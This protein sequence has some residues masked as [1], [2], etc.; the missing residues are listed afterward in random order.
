MSSPGL[1]DALLLVGDGC[2]VDPSVSLGQSSPGEEQLV[3]G[4]TVGL[5]PG[6]RTRTHPRPDGGELGPGSRNDPD[7]QPH[8]GR[9]SGGQDPPSTGG[10]C[11]HHGFRGE[12]SI[13]HTVKD[14]HTGEIQPS[15]AALLSHP[16][17]CHRIR[18]H[19]GRNGPSSSG[20]AAGIGARC[21]RSDCSSSG[22]RRW[23]GPQR[24]R[25]ALPPVT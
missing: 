25:G 16:A 2:G 9:C 17:A 5:S 20:A 19:R 13:N 4:P 6:T 8:G 1:V 15:G 21:S 18:A 3:P 7:T 11:T 10:R 23:S 12:Q 24:Q 22:L 14:T